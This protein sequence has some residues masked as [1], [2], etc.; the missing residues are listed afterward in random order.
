[1]DLNEPNSTASSSRRGKL[2]ASVKDT[3]GNVIGLIQ[4]P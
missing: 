2:L 4:A 3:D 1:V